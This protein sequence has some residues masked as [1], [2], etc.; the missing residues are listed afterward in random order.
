MEV[1]H[2]L[3][4]NNRANVPVARQ[5]YQDV[6]GPGSRIWMKSW[7]QNSGSKASGHFLPSWAVAVSLDA[8]LPWHDK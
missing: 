3:R 8:C 2:A 5:L 1:S 6:L 4:E 7:V